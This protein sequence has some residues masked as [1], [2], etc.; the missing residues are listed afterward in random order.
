MYTTADPPALTLPCDG[1]EYLRE[2]YPDLYA[3]LDAAYIVDAD[4]FVTPALQ[5]R[6]PIGAGQGVGLSAY[7]VNEIAG[8]E[9][10]ALTE[11]ENGTHSHVDSGHSHTYSPPGATGLAVS[12]GELPVLLPNL[13]PGIT[14]SASAN[15]QPSGLGDAHN[16][17][18]PVNAVKFAVYYQ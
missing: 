12:P 8:E 17:I 4:H 1:E 2:D 16:T 15:I 7:A 9:T 3:Q 6:S 5:S 18:H 10:H 13:L 14:G 11:D